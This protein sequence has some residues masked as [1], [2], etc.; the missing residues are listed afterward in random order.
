MEFKEEQIKDVFIKNLEKY[1]DERGVLIE[2][3]RT[4]NIEDMVQPA[5][6]YVS[7]TRPGFARGPHEHK[8]QT[9]IFSFIGPGNF[10]VQL[11]DNRKD[12]A[13]YRNKM[14]IMAGSN[15]PFTIIIPNGI[16]HGYKNISETEDGM[17]INYPDKLYRGREK[18][19]VVDEVRHEDKED[20]FY[21]DFIK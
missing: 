10:K 18:R 4:D 6:S 20:K 17:V 8:Y 15:N 21:L 5:M 3:Y 2:T 1:A 19:D 11:W 9:D 13:T 12:S 14:V 7:F 16:V